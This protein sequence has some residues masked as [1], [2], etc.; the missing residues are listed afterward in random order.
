MKCIV[1]D[2]DKLIRIQLQKFIERTKECEL[3]GTF[4]SADEALQNVNLDNVDLIF[5]DIE[6]PGMSGLDFLE[7]FKHLPAV[8]VISAKERYAVDAFDFDVDDYILKPIEY[9][10]FLKAVDRVK[11]KFVKFKPSRLENNG[12]FIKENSTTFRKILYEDIYWIEA[13]ENYVSIHTVRGRF[14][15]HFTM[16]SLERL[17]PRN[18][19]FR[20][21]RSYIVNLDKIEVIEDNF[22]VIYFRGQKKLIPIAKAVRDELLSRLNIVKS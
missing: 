6:M 7:I 19:F 1:I 21:H 22:A 13:L 10:R 3:L 2:D 14:T 5:L 15:I 17:L 11:E 18:K 12:I 8:V 20:I 4:S 9:Q 16:K